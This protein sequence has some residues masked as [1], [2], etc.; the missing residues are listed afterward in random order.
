MLWVR[1]K[2]NHDDWKEETSANLVLLIVLTL[3]LLHLSTLAPFLILVKHHVKSMSPAER[4]SW[5]YIRWLL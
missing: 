4:I 3:V 2:G 1:E 5:V